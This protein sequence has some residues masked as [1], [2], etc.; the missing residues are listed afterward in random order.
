MET[1]RA[2]KKLLKEMFSHNLVGLEVTC[3]QLPTTLKSIIAFDYIKTM[4]RELYIDQ[5][6]TLAL[7]ES[8]CVISAIQKYPT[9]IKGIRHNP[10][11]EK[12]DL[13]NNVIMH[14]VTNQLRKA[15]Y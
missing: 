15:G 13:S 8:S 14:L 3:R 1:E 11:V 12:L 2:T 4:A 9:S 6:T 5:D 10:S 7:K